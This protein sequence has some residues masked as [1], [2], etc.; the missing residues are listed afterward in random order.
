MT[1]KSQKILNILE[2]EYPQ[3]G[4]GLYHQNIFQLLVAVLLSAQTTDENVNKIASRLFKEVKTPEDLLKFSPEKLEKAIYSAGF[5]RQKTQALLALSKVLVEKFGSSVP[6]NMRD[7]TSLKGIARKS[8]N[9]ILSVGY[10]ISE[11]I[12]VDTHVKRL[13]I[14]LGLSREKTPEKIEKDL[15]CIFPKKDW[16]KINHLFIAH[17]RKVCDARRP[18]CAGCCLRDF[19]EFTPTLSNS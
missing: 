13:S 18:L 17:G 14:R 5:Y 6:K 10:G 12:A 3:S 8:A 15:C 2:G 4:C 7:L 9:I 1:N 19:C 11:G 16:H